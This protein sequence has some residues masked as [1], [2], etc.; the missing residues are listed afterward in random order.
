MVRKEFYIWE[1]A[2]DRWRREGMPPV[3]RWRQDKP[4][5]DP[6]EL[7]QAQL[8]GFDGDID[9]HGI[10]RLGWCEPAFVP[11]QKESVLQSGDD[12][13]II[14]D[15]ALRVM[16]VYKG[17][18]HGSM[19]TY[20]KHAV[21]CDRDWHEEVE[22]LLDLATPQRHATL[23][24][25]IGR[26]RAAQAPGKMIVQQCVGGYMYLRALVGAEEVCYMLVDNPALIHKMM[27]RWLELADDLTAR[28]QAAG[29][30]YDT[31]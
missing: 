27:R 10:G 16:K 24:D 28:V 3:Y 5:P 31:F 9:R 23:D 30:R 4:K 6:G 2:L 18:R 22:P 15:G 8:F 7:T 14:R 29:V 25:E 21:T 20:I 13:E 26:L 19:P 11:A 12:Y 17:R 1:E